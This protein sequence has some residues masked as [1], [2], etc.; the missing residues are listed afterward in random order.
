MPCIF[1]RMLACMFLSLSLILVHWISNFIY[2]YYIRPGVLTEYKRKHWLLLSL[3]K[4]NILF[5]LLNRAFFFAA[6]E[7]DRLEDRQFVTYG[8]FRLPEINIQWD[9]L[10][11]N[12][13]VCTMENCFSWLHKVSQ[14]YYF[15][16]SGWQKYQPKIP[17]ISNI[18]HERRGFCVTIFLLMLRICSLLF[19]LHLQLQF[20]FTLTITYGK[21]Y[22]KYVRVLFSYPC[23]LELMPQ[24]YVLFWGHR[25]ISICFSS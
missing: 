19:I 10:I 7:K 17:A 3:R 13:A 2:V 5:L 1:R 8:Y 12:F 15:S 23:F 4:I 9:N 14:L 22:L 11:P 24:N 6:K 25:L 18:R 20:S 21:I 16:F